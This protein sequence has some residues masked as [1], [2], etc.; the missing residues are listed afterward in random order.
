MAD[1]RQTRAQ[2]VVT[3]N[4]G[5]Q[6]QLINGAQGSETPL[7]VVHLVELLEQSYRREQ[8]GNPKE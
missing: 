3:T 7:H 5:C 4:P 1:I 8:N 6:F 2:V